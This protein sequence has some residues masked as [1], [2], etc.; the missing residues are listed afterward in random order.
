MGLNNNVGQA[1]RAN[2]LELIP[3]FHPRR[4]WLYVKHRRWMFS[5]EYSRLQDT[6]I[7]TSAIFDAK[8]KALMRPEREDEIVRSELLHG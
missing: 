4:V 1:A 3:Q 8:T 5:D 2:V 7:G 6:Y